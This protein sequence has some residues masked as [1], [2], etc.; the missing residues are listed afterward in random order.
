MTKNSEKDSNEWIKKANDDLSFAKVGFEETEFYP[1][2]CMMCHQAVE[3]YLKAYIVKTK[4]ALTQKEK[5]HNLLFLAETCLSKGLDLLSDYEHELRILSGVYI[6]AKYPVQTPQEFSRKQ[7]K[8]L[9]EATEE[10]IKKIKE[11]L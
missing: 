10:I 9:I 11:K 5:T 8:E 6:P 2:I 3:K 1:Q 7:T 4:G